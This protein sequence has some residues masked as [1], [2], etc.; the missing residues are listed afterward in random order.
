ME[1]MHRFSG[2]HDLVVVDN[3]NIMAWEI[4]PYY[5]LAEVWGASVEVLCFDVPLGTCLERQIHDVPREIIEKMR[6]RMDT[7]PPENHGGEKIE[8]ILGCVLVSN[9]TMITQK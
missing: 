4:A 3:T 1:V 8:I 5:R 6:A 2:E 9:I 7:L